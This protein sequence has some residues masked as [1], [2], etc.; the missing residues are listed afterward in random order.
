MET[1]I[2]SVN[3]KCGH[4]GTSFRSPIFFGDVGSFETATTAGNKAQC[5]KCKR[6]IDCNKENMSYILEG[7]VGGSMGPDFGVKPK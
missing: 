2:K 7:S 5:P 3:I 1:K 6:M 4:C